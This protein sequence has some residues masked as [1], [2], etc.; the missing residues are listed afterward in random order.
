MKILYPEAHFLNYG[1]GWFLHDYR[2]RKVVEH[3]GAIDGM[4]A[5]VAMMPEEKLGLVVLTNMNGSILPLAIMYGYST[6]TSARRRAT[7]ARTCSRRSKH[8]KRKERGAE[9]S[10]SRSGQR[11]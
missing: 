9:E 11:H 6:P 3:G 4:R 7:G 8:S 5:Q 2:G 10:R 1:L